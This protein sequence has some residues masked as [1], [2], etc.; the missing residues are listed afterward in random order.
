MKKDISKIGDL[1]EQLDMLQ[2]MSYDDLSYELMQLNIEY[3]KIKRLLSPKESR[4]YR[5]FMYLFEIEKSMRMTHNQPSIGHLK[6]PRQVML[7]WLELELDDNAVV[8]GS[9]GVDLIKEN[10]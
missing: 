6:G 5:D 10:D 4:A 9:A 8:L 3:E 1:A 2:E 7:S